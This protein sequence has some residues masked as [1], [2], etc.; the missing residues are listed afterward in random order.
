MSE[1][2]TNTVGLAGLDEAG[3][4]KPGHEATFDDPMPELRMPDTVTA[5]EVDPNAL[6]GKTPALPEVPE[7]WKSFPDRGPIENMKALQKNLKTT[8]ELTTLDRQTGFVYIEDQHRLI[9]GKLFFRANIQNLIHLC[10]DPKDESPT[11]DMGMV[12][13]LHTRDIRSGKS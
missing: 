7:K 4:E 11:V 5:S 8:D 10:Q 12:T 9:V 2:D 13:V 6:K 3:R 1:L